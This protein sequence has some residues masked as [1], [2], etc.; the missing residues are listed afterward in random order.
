MAQYFGKSSNAECPKPHQKCATQ[1]ENEKKVRE[2]DGAHD[3]NETWSL[4]FRLGEGREG[5]PLG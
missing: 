1:Q 3:V 5:M 4:G 2:R